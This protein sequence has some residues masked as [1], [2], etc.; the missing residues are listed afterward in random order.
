MRKNENNL[1]QQLEI[2]GAGEKVCGWLNGLE[3]SRGSQD[4]YAYARVLDSE[5]GKHPTHVAHPTPNFL[6]PQVSKAE[7]RSDMGDMGEVFSD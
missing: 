6:T 4:V 7:A 1:F 3:I 5:S 2:K